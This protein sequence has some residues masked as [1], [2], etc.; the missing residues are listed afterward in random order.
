MQRAGTTFTNYTVSDSFCC[1]SRASI[2]TGNYPHDTAVYTNNGPDGG[3]HIFHRKGEED[4]TFATALQS[5]G[6]RTAFMGKYLNG[7]RPGV[8][9]RVGRACRSPARTTGSPPGWDEWDVAGE[10]YGEYDY[11]LEREPPR[12]VLRQRRRRTTSPT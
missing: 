1:P 9:V 4:H 11:A 5:V 2:L 3:F 7:Y 10:G 6:Y 12:R 8:A